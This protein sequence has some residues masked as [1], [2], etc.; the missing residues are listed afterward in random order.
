MTYE[1][2]TVKVPG[3]NALNH[4]IKNGNKKVSVVEHPDGSL[5]VIDYMGRLVYDGYD[6]QDAADAIGKV[7][8]LEKVFYTD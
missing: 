7:L 8:G 3:A 5:H 2:R 1:I 6:Q 4:V